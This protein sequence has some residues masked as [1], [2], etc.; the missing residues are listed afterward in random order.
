[1]RRELSQPLKEE[2]DS[3]C[4]KVLIKIIP[5]IWMAYFSRVLC[6]FSTKVENWNSQVWNFSQFQWRGYENASARQW[7]PQMR[8]K[9]IN[10]L[11]RKNRNSVYVSDAE[12]NEKTTNIS[13]FECLA[14]FINENVL[15][16]L[17]IKI[18]TFTSYCYFIECDLK[19][20][21]TRD[22]RSRMYVICNLYLHF[23]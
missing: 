9:L 19:Y 5:V 21:D 7:K 3:T 13:C 4:G 12:I 14:I 16:L 6:K 23:L 2:L 10:I 15:L 1:M 18:V 17:Y 8:K 20:R 11:A 22:C